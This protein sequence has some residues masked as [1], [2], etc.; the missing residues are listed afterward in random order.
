M[1]QPYEL[2]NYS[3]TTVDYPSLLLDHPLVDGM[4]L[5][6]ESER[7]FVGICDE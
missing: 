3:K 1:D 4:L 2:L 6:G 5:H 7:N